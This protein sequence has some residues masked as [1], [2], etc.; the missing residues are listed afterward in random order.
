MAPRFRF[1]AHDPQGGSHTGHLE[2]AARQEALEELRRQ[3]LT[4]IDL[5]ETREASQATPERA[6]RAP[7]SGGRRE[8]AELALALAD[9]LEA[10]AELDAALETL[11][12]QPWERRGTPGMVE[13]LRRRLRS[14]SDLSQALAQ[15][16]VPPL[17]ALAARAGE[18]AGDLAGALRRS[19]RRLAAEVRIR[20]RVLLALLYPALTLVVGLLVAAAMLFW[21]LPGVIASFQEA[22][23]ALPWPTRLLLSLAGLGRWPGLLLPLGALAV[24]GWSVRASRRGPLRRLR[25][26]WLLRA[27]LVGPVVRLEL[28]ER[29][30]GAMAALL[31]SGVPLLEA[32]ETAGDACGNQAMAR[33][34]ERVRGAVASGEAL[35]RALDSVPGFD[36]VARRVVAVGEETGRLDRSFA[37]L[38]ERS[39]ENL[40]ETLAAAVALLEPLLVLL[41]AAGVGLLVAALLLPILEMGEL[42]M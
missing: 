31:A 21:V 6:G 25:D 2:A 38:A 19:A 29:F 10:G 23:R 36:P 5:T 1:R 18:E 26:G 27:P 42:V 11:A 14:G 24:C 37:R 7:R 20:R 41:L 3:G 4:P 40:A 28:R 39:A 12:E 17:L 16:E 33:A 22:G 8:A 35:S 15:E 34:L 30:S 9:L 32:L 13:R